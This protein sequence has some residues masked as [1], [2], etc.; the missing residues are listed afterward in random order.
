MCFKTPCRTPC[1]S[2]VLRML[3]KLYR[4]QSA[5]VSEEWCWQTQRSRVTRFAWLNSQSFKVS[6]AIQFI[7]ICCTRGML[8]SVKV[9]DFSIDS[10]TNVPQE[11]NFWKLNSLPLYMK[12][13]IM[14][15]LKG[16]RCSWAKTTHC[17]VGHMAPTFYVCIPHYTSHSDLWTC[18]VK[19]TACGYH[20]TSEWCV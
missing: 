18:I 9:S 5:V 12:R 14:S 11:F 17:W 20:Q 6:Y 10:N 8:Y 1:N 19:W 3:V 7:E 4:H 13:A 2:P 16:N 15:P